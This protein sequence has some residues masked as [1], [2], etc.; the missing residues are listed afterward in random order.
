MMKKF[1]RKVI[2]IKDHLNLEEVTIAILGNANSGKSTMVGILTNPG[3]R[4][5]TGRDFANKTVSADILDNG[6]GSARQP[7]LQYI[8][9][10]ETGRTSSVSYNFMLRNNTDSLKEKV[11]SLVDLAGHEAYLK[12]TIRGLTSS[13]PDY[14][15]VCIEKSITK[16][17]LEHIRLLHVLE[18][19]FALIMTK[20][21]IIPSEKIKENL[22]SIVSHVKRLNR[23]AFIVKSAG[24]DA[25]MVNA[26]TTPIILLSNK[27]GIGYE[28]LL[29]L[30]DIIEKRVKKSM[31]DAFVVDSLYTVQGFGLVVCGVAGVEIE[32]NTEMYIGPFNSAQESNVFVKVKIRSIHDDYRNFVDT[33]KVGSRGCL[34]I[35]IEPKY[36][37][38]IRAGLVLT[39]TLDVVN[40]IKKF[41]AKVHIF[42]GTMCTITPGYNA[43]VNTGVVKGLVRFNTITKLNSEELSCTR[44]GETILAELEFLYSTYCISQGEIFVFREGSTIGYGQVL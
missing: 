24:I 17:T 33:L 31:P 18:I 10:K 7:V 8:H 30:I 44:G 29:P 43:V 5:L 13:Y 21:D 26:V 19:P 20:V 4:T 41:N 2:P 27:L 16:I 25:K 28:K 35:K 37:N 39:K 23:Q 14:A 1:V 40:P 34:C 42:D 11:V 36:R 32:K 22:K 6:N 3:I 9:E 12:T 15:L 38:K